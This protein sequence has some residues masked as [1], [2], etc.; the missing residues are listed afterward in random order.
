[1]H[2]KIIFLSLSE[3]ACADPGTPHD[4]QQDA[5]SFENGQ[6]VRYTCDRAGFAPDDDVIICN[7]GIWEVYDEITM[8]STGTEVT[9]SIDMRPS[10]NGK[11]NIFI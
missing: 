7:E 6:L 10:C 8:M 3:T 4:G 1:M 5:N 2:A 9:T 11:T